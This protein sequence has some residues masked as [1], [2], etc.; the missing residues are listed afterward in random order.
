MGRCKFLSIAILCLR[1]LRLYGGE[2]EIARK[3]ILALG[4]TMLR[5]WR[6]LGIEID[7]E[8]GEGCWEGHEVC[9]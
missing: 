7:K 2:G 5:L 4:L 3:F 9:A 6:V 8:R 1:R